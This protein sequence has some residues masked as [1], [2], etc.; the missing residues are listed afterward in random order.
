[1]A[2][3]AARTA[4][5]LG[6]AKVVVLAPHA[7]HEL[8]AGA[9]D[10]QAAREEGVEFEFIVEARGVKLAKTGKPTAVECV[11]LRA[12]QGRQ[13]RR[14][15]GQRASSVKTEHRDR[16][17]GLGAGP[18]RG[19][20]RSAPSGPANG[21][22]PTTTPAAPRTEGVFASGD[23]VTGAKSAIHAMAGG[24]R[25]A[26]AI[27][28]WL[29]GADLQELESKLALYAGLPYLQQLNDAP[30]LGE[31][32]Q[33]LAER[34][35]VWLKMGIA[36]EPESRTVDA[37]G[38]RPSSARPRFDEVEKGFKRKAAKAEAARCL[39]CTCPALGRLRPADARRGVRHHRATSWS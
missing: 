1:M 3:D 2:V 4:R 10:L 32:G 37:H 5:R 22:R 26:L 29:A 28:A 6:A 38:A 24:K 31:L 23:A 35:P 12:R 36:A 20:R 15:Q 14:G 7:E 8:P 33:R 18:R 17:P 9:R 34:S 27:D 16:R 13:A 19:R 11:R 25:A 39:Q 30:Q 21:S